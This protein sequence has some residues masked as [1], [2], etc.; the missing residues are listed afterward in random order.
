MNKQKVTK[1]VYLTPFI[2]VCNM[3]NESPL[4]A[5]SPVAGGHNDAGDDE[6][7]N[8]KEFSFDDDYDIWQV[9]NEQLED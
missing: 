9:S 2:E 8:A 4:L 7:L 6:I 5:N 3:N 1:Q